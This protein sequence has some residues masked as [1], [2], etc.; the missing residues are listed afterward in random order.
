[1]LAVL[2]G[3]LMLAPEAAGSESTSGKLQWGSVI[4]LVLATGAAGLL[5]R[6]VHEVPDS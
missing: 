3:L 2:G 4:L 1:M 6:S 5:V